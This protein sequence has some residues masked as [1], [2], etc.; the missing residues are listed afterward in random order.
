M[1]GIPLVGRKFGTMRVTRLLPGRK[2]RV[3]CSACD[4]SKTVD[5]SNVYRMK[6]CGC[7]RS[8]L[9]GA[10]HLKHGAKRAGQRTR[11]YETWVNIK[12]RCYNRK[13]EDYPNYGGRGIKVC[14]RWRKSFSAF[15]EDMKC[16]PEPSLSI[17]R[18]NVNGP[19]SKE[20]CYWADAHTQRM[21]QRRMLEAA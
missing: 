5:K 15:L 17:E 10:G 18:R 3:H 6:S 13:N 1:S 9:I 2:C 16:K 8:V 4:R 14:S 20:N 12:S 19:Y 11:E 21:N 7:L